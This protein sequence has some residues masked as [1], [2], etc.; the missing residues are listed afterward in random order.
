MW[1]TEMKYL[2]FCD[3]F[4]RSG[5]PGSK[6]SGRSRS[7]RGWDNSI[8]SPHRGRGSSR[9]SSQRWSPDNPSRRCADVLD[10]TVISMNPHKCRGTDKSLAF[11]ISWFAVQ[12]KEFVL[13]GLK[14]LEQ[15]SHKCVE[16]RGGI[17]RVKFFFQSCSL[18]F[19]KPKT[20]QPP[21]LYSLNNNLICSPAKHN[22]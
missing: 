22:L 8:L 18:F 12:T 6:S 21:I 2:F 9:S 15:Q 20:Y 5:S 7:S 16:L 17:C 3:F 10:I 4:Y 11:P 14:K 1:L 13:D 19:I